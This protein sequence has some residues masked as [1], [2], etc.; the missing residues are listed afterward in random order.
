[1]I[2]TS[3]TAAAQAAVIPKANI[4]R[5]PR[6]RGVLPT[7]NLECD[8]ASIETTLVAGHVMALLDLA[9]IQHDRVVIG[10]ASHVWFVQMAVALPKALLDA[11]RVAPHF[12]DLG[13][14]GRA[15]V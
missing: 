7:Q 12:G 5:M 2:S 15:H 4:A 13:E 14:I 3:G 10:R 8:L 11:T 6:S 1:M 9:L